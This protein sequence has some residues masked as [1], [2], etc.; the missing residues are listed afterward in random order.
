MIS[1]KIWKLFKE[2]EESL[3]TPKRE[4]ILHLE[5]CTDFS[6]VVVDDKRIF[7]FNSLEELES[8]LLEK[9]GRSK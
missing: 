9:L 4:A 5:I 2:Y 8:K 1:K 3:H 6:G 7:Y